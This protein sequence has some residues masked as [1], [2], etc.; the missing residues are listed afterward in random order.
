MSRL[1]YC[2]EMLAQGRISRRVLLERA[3]ALGATSAL[4]ASLLSPSLAVAAPKKGGF[5]R[6]GMAD[7]SQT[8]SLDP[9]TWPGSFTV[10][11]LG[12]AMCNTLTEIMPNRSV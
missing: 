7:G 5:A 1:D 6:F 4:S 3:A 9:A 8:D 11:A 10:S 12:G 2:T